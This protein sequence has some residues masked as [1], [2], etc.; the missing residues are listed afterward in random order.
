MASKF[1]RPDVNA[2]IFVD[3]DLLT[4][5]EGWEAPVVFTVWAGKSHGVRAI[6]F[7]AS[8]ASEAL[9]QIQD[10]HAATGAGQ[11]VGSK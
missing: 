9:A 7:S 6:C 2:I 3:D 8:P 4:A 10:R 11:G 5:L 1:P